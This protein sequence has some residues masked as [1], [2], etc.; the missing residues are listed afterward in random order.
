MNI[1]ER[2]ETQRQ[3]LQT[4]ATVRERRLEEMRQIEAEYL[5]TE[6]EVRALAGLL[7]EEQPTEAGD[8]VDPEK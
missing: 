1:Q 5:R 4:L 7:K 2:L 3:R 6:G 8:E